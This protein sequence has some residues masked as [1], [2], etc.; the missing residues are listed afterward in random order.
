MILKNCAQV[1]VNVCVI[2]ELM[3]YDL[4]LTNNKCE[5]FLFKLITLESFKNSGIK[6]S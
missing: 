4:L 2:E 1:S 6:W 3:K 5:R